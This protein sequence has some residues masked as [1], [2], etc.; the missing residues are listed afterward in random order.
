VDIPEGPRQATEAMKVVMRDARYRPLLE[1]DGELWAQ[2]EGRRPR[3]VPEISRDDWFPPGI[4]ESEPTPAP[5]GEGT[6]PLPPP[7]PPVPLV[8][9]TWPPRR[10]PNVFDTSAPSD[11]SPGGRYRSADYSC[12]PFT[13]RE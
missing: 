3:G 10:T 5:S 8:L 6:S 13:S 2:V 12:L 11:Y 7:R 4:T 9:T 1:R